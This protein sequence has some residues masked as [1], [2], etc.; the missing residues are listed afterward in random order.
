MH[1][2]YPLVADKKQK[3]KNRCIDVKAIFFEIVQKEITYIHYLIEV[4]LKWGLNNKGHVDKWTKTKRREE[5]RMTV[6]EGTTYIGFLL[7]LFS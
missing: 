4:Q 3:I 7:F 2:S 1:M 6:D 5:D